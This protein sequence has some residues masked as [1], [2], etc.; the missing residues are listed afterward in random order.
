MLKVYIKLRAL[1]DMQSG[2]KKGEIYEMENDVFDKKNGMAFCQLSQKWEILKMEI[3]EYK[4]I[5]V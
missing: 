3:I 4:K 5:H 2:H 1:E